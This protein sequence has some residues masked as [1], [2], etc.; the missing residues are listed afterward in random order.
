MGFYSK[1]SHNIVE[2]SLCYIQNRVIDMFASLVFEN[3]K[4]LN[5]EGYN[6]ETKSGDIRHII[7]KRGY[8]TGQIMVVIVVNDKE[9]LRD[10]RF[11]TLVENIGKDK[12]TSLALNLNDKDTN[13]IMGD[14][15]TYIYG[16]KYIT[17]IIGDYTYYISPKSFFQ[18]NTVQTEVLYNVLKEKLALD[19]SE[20]L[21]DLYSGVG[22]IGIFLSDS[23]KNVYG[24]EIEEEA[25]YM[26]NMNLKLNHI[27]NCEYIAGAA[28]VKVAEFKERGIK[29]DVIVV[30]P[31]RKGLDENCIKYILDFAP[32][33][34]G[35]IS[36]NPATLV[37][38]LKILESKYEIKEIM[39]VDMF[40][41]TANV[42][43]V[44]LLC[45]KET[46]KL[47]KK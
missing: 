9:L 44:S 4:K 29:P 12:I 35:Y 11:A 13:K 24:I 42:E 10:F 18:V 27:S 2:G 20:I 38:D 28:E 46:S 34:V 16:D 41:H 7:I 19:G 45:L 36:C 31:P 21:F 17:D 47:L 22:S 5:F 30:D 3:L 1:R 37:R 15:T 26:A 43:C 25:V 23:V 33:K 6:E 40:P 14:V 39:P 32:K 8:H